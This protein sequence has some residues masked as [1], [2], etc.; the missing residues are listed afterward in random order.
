MMAVSAGFLAQ[1]DTGFSAPFT[2]D[3][4]PDPRARV[5]CWTDPS[6]SSLRH[7]L[8]TSALL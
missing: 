4:R 2:T 7:L 6:L 5:P 8:L 3:F 1:W